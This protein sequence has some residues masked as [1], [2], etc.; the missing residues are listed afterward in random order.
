[1]PKNGGAIF[2]IQEFGAFDT[3]VSIY[4]RRFL[5]G[6]QTLTINFACK[7]QPCNLLQVML[8]SRIKTGVLAHLFMKQGGLFVLFCTDEIL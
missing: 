2:L 1:M 5:L 8:C 3:L 7:F 6:A 4:S